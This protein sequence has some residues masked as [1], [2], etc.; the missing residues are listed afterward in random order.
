MVFIKNYRNLKGTFFEAGADF[1]GAKKLEADLRERGIIG[2]AE[3]EADLE[4][5]AKAEAEAQAKADTEAKTKED[6]ERLVVL[7]ELAT[8]MHL[9]FSDDITVSEL[10]A[11]V[12][13][14]LDAVEAEIN[15]E[16][17]D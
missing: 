6:A 8:E 7:K 5:K 17:K 15:K 13:K 16:K 4:A 9:E 12:Q 10:E 11:L 14:E 3:N 1:K 2:D